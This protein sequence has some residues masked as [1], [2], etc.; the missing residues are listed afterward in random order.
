MKSCII[1]GTAFLL[2][3]CEMISSLGGGS[4]RRTRSETYYA[5]GTIQ[6]FRTE[7]DGQMRGTQKRYYPSGVV[8]SRMRFRKS[9]R[10]TVVEFDSAGNKLVSYGLTPD[11]NMCGRYVE[12][13]ADRTIIAS[14]SYR[15]LPCYHDVNRDSVLD[16]GDYRDNTFRFGKTGRWLERDSTTGVVQTVWYADY[17]LTFDEVASFGVVPAEV[18]T[19]ERIEYNYVPRFVNCVG[20]RGP[21]AGTLRPRER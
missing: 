10:S 2:C 14:G 13:R 4:N 9:G 6:S 12:V 11:G 15:L 17:V 20:K 7:I 8:Q 3:G 1:S 5:N 21:P 19:V 18:L 16:A